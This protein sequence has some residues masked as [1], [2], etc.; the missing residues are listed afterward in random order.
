MKTKY[1]TN[2]QLI[3]AYFG[4]NFQGVI[5]QPNS[6]TIGEE[7]KI[8]FERNGWERISLHFTSRTDAGV[9]AEQNFV[10]IHVKQKVGE[11]DVSLLN[12]QLPPHLRIISLFENQEF[13]AITPKLEKTYQYFFSK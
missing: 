10:Q 6:L 1:P 12:L 2:F 9:H 13:Q 3:I 4:T 7:L 5:K 8:L 11:C